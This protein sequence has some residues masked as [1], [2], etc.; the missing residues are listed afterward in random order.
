MLELSI[1]GKSYTNS[2]GDRTHALGAVKLGIKEKDFVCMVGPSGCGKTSLL[3]I[4]AGLSEPTAGEVCYAVGDRPR[5]GYVFQEPRLMPWMTVLDNVLLVTDKSPAAAELAFE[6]LGS[7]RLA[8]VANSYPSELSGGMRRRVA[9]ARAFVIRPQLLLMDEP[10][11]SLDQPLAESLRR[12]LLQLLEE[13]PTS[14]VF[15]SH[16]LEETIKLGRRILFFSPSPGSVILETTVP[17]SA[18]KSK[19]GIDEFRRRLLGKY[20]E[21]LQGEL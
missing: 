11:V 15:V 16:D 4:I 8:E 6:L 2:R 5:V 10:F 20:P 21:L 9:L 19:G 17:A 14:V 13:H 7:M 3:N 1:S 12:L 18:K